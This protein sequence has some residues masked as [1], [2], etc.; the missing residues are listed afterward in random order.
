MNAYSGGCEL[1][2]NL[3]LKEVSPVLEF[4]DIQCI[5]QARRESN[6]ITFNCP[7]YESKFGRKNRRFKRDFQCIFT[8]CDSEVDYCNMTSDNGNRCSLR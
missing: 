4:G 1:R 6:H 5:D 7:Y 8:E 2:E 3:E